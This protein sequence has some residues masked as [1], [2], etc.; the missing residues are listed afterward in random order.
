MENNKTEI[1]TTGKKEQVP[2]RRNKPH[3]ETSMNEG[4]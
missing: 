1:M 4:H 3:I 2:R